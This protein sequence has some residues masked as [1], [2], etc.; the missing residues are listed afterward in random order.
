MLEPSQP[1]PSPTPARGRPGRQ[2]VEQHDLPQRTAAVQAMRVEVRDPVRELGL[3]APT[4]GASRDERARRSQ[5]A[6]RAP[7]S[8]RRVRRCGA[9]RASGIASIGSNRCSN[10]SHTAPIAGVPPPGS[11]SNTSAAPIC[12]SALL[13]ACSS[14]RNAPSSAVSRS[15]P[16]VAA[17]RVALAHGTRCSAGC[18]Q[19]M[20]A[21]RRNYR[22][23]AG[24]SA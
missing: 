10:S 9:R 24:S 23:A 22:P 13:S 14:S 11:G 19:R 2:T 12:I 7:R 20:I 17:P 21:P 18:H 16:G 1:G 4:T 15:L 3:A 6:D 5:S 8:A